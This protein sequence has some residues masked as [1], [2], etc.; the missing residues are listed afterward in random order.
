[1]R[2]YE[3]F[4]QRGVNAAT[5]MV[6]GLALWLPS[7]Y[8]YGAV[9]ML[10]LALVGLPLWWGKPVPQGSRWLACVITLMVA[11]LLLDVPFGSGSLK[12]LERPLKYLLALPCLLLLTQVPPSAQAL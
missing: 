2:A 3:S 12:A 11:V 1:M 5:F 9:A 8:S 10:L 6:P 7:G 4:V